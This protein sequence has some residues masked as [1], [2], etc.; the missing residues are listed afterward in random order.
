MVALIVFGGH[1]GHGFAVQAVHPELLKQLPGML[2]FMAK[3]IR[4]DQKK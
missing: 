1:E 2:E 3:G 4:E